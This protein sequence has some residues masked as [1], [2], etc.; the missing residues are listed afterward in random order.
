LV[1]LRQQAVEIDNIKIYIQHSNNA[2]TATNIRHELYK[3]VEQVDMC[4][5]D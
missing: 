3:T 2:K 4:T 5:N 1:E